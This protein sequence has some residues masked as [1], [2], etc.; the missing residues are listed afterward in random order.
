MGVIL[1]APIRG[2]WIAQGLLVVGCEACLQRRVISYVLERPW[3]QLIRPTPFT[4]KRIMRRH[5][6]IGMQS[7]SAAVARHLRF[8]V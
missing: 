5:L 2:S 3:E 6:E 4:L 8:R 7:K 1:T